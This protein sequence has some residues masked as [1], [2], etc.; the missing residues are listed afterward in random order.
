MIPAC[1]LV[2]KF[3]LELLNGTDDILVVLGNDPLGLLGVDAHPAQ[4]V[5]GPRQRHP[6]QVGQEIILWSTFSL[7]C[8]RQI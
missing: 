1:L 7:W 5:G 4:Q 8:L 2:L 6:P 3:L